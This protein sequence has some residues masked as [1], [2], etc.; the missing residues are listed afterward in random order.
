M[1][2]DIRNTGDDH[3]RASSVLPPSQASPPQSPILVRDEDEALHE[4]SE[5]E[6]A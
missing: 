3:W 5:P 4:D 1:F 2:E 6:E